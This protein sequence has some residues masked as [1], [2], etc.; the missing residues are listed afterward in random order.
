M[1]KNLQEQRGYALNRHFA[2]KVEGVVWRIALLHQ[3]SHVVI[4]FFAASFFMYW[5]II[6][7]LAPNGAVTLVMKV[8]VLDNVSY[9]VVSVVGNSLKEDPN[10]Y[11]LLS[12]RRNQWKL[13][14][15]F[16]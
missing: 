5:F 9:L 12:L 16:D 2:F 7:S 8:L 14:F 3:L 6:R 1:H 10:F 11:N 4:Q 13:L 15:F